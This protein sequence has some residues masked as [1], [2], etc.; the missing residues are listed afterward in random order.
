MIVFAGIYLFIALL[1]GGH[2]QDSMH[3]YHK[4]VGDEGPFIIG[5]VWPIWVIFKIFWRKK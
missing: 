1:V 3:P 4:R 2:I 5:L